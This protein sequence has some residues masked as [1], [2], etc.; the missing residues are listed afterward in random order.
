VIRPLLALLLAAAHPMHTSV[1]ELVTEGGE[2][3]IAI[4]VYADDL[5]GAVPGDGPTADSALAR[6]VRARFV[7]ADREGRPVPLRWAGAERTD[8]AVVLRLQGRLPGGLRGARVAST[9]LHERFHDQV[10]VVRATEAGHTSTL[11]FLRGDGPRA[12][13]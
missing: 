6:Y 2:T 1:A 11:L 12:L 13:R 5:A 8:G 3:R 10:N 9:L 4:R 7:L